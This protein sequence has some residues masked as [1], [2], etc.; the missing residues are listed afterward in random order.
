MTKETMQEIVDVL[1]SACAADPDAM[2]ELAET[3]VPCNENMLNHPS[4]PV[5]EDVT[6]NKPSYRVGL[7]GI[8]AGISQPAEPPGHRI[9]G[10]Y[11]NDLLT[12]F[13]VMPVVKG[14]VV[15]EELANG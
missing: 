1:N 7:L 6:D 4:I 14:T 10:V 8:L 12:G 11:D 5:V 15:A 13:C 2:H 9:A 3:R